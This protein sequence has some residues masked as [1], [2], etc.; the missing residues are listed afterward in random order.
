MDM[1]N[2]QARL[3][4]FGEYFDKEVFEDVREGIRELKYERKNVCPNMGPCGDYSYFCAEG[5]PN[6]EHA[7]IPTAEERLICFTTLE[8]RCMGEYD[9]CGF[10]NGRIKRD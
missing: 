3:T 10:Y 5:L 6:K 9:K 7:A 2:L 8:A 4:S 1:E